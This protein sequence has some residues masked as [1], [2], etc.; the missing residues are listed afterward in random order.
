MIDHT[1][2]A[3]L[4]TN[5]TVRILEATE[6]LRAAGEGARSDEGEEG[7]PVKTGRVLGVPR[8]YGRLARGYCR[9][10]LQGAIKLNQAASGW[11]WDALACR[12]A[13]GCTKMHTAKAAND[14]AKES[15]TDDS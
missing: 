5:S 7:A 9:S 11:H 1:R 10:T 13:S 14:P 12:G 4:R 2:S 8:V 3:T 15:V 6:R